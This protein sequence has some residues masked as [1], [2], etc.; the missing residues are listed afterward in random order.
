MDITDKKP[1]VLTGDND[2]I[3]A[4]LLE[5]PEL[6]DDADFRSDVFEGETSPKLIVTER[7]F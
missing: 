7:S 5:Y 1:G 2:E 6:A 4:L 3:E